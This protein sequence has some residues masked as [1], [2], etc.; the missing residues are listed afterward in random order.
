MLIGSCDRI[1]LNIMVQQQQIKKGL[2]TNIRLI[3]FESQTK[4][5]TKACQ[6]YKPALKMS[7][8]YFSDAK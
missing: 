5:E 6:L 1:V 4:L 3:I 2:H 8:V 7:L